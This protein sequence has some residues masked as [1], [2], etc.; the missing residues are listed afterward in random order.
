MKFN[1]IRMLWIDLFRT[2]SHENVAYIFLKKIITYNH[3]IKEF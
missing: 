2:K 3:I 1:Q